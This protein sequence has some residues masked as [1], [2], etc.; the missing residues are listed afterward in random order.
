[1]ATSRAVV[2]NDVADEF[3]ERIAKRAGSMRIG[4]GMDP[5]T[6]IGPSV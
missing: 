4:D 3:V 5:Q 6:E 1:T 2:V